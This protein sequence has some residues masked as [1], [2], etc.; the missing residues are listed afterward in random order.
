M[1]VNEDGRYI[2]TPTPN[3]PDIPARIVLE[4]RAFGHTVSVVR[5]IARITHA[6][7]PYVLVECAG[8]HAVVAYAVTNAQA[9]Q[10]QQSLIRGESWVGVRR[11]GWVLEIEPLMACIP[12][13]AQIDA[14]QAEAI[15]EAVH[16]GL[17][18]LSLDV[19]GS[20][21]AHNRAAHLSIEADGSTSNKD[22]V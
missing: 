17:A 19:A 16:Y 18:Q 5:L 8:A 7:K 13:Q 11:Q 15:A 3:I 21:E 4:V 22:E 6:S 20:T 1:E 2:T 9:Q 10:L 12:P 14:E